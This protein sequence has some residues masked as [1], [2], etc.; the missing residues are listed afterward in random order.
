MRRMRKKRKNK[1]RPG[2]VANSTPS[3]D[4]YGFILLH[5][6]AHQIVACLAQTL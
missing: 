1:L 6:H 5:P 4:T 3:T 2:K